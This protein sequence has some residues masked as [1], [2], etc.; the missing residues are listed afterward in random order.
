ME[1]TL[2]LPDIPC[3]YFRKDLA[4]VAFTT[5]DV[6]KHLLNLR[7][8]TDKSPGP[9]M[10]HPRLLKECAHELACNLYTLY[11]ESLDDGNIPQDW[12][13]DSNS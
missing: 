3:R 2:H 9:D 12:K 11:R 8:K 7:K 10:I 1:D 5:V 4:D 13:Y 6:L